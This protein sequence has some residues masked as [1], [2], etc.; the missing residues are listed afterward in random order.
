[1]KCLNLKI[2]TLNC[3]LLPPY[4][5]FTLM[6]QKKEL[7]CKL[8]SN[9]INKI[10]PDI[11]LN[12]EIF[13][14]NFKDNKWANIMQN[15]FNKKY[16]KCKSDIV[17]CK[18]TNNGLY[19][20]IRDSANI[21]IISTKFI[22]CNRGRLSFIGIIRDN[23]FLHTKIYIKNIDKHI[24]I[25]NVHMLSN[26]CNC[27]KK[28]YEKLRRNCIN[29]IMEY[30]EININENDKWVLGGDFNCNVYNFINIIKEKSL[31]YD[32]DTFKKIKST[33]LN[34]STINTNIWFAK[35]TNEEYIDHI[36]TNADMN[37][38]PYSSKYCISKDAEY[39]SDHFPVITDIKL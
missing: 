31:I 26:E 8:I 1:M 3:C 22:N 14:W 24:H 4:S 17:N 25:F 18:L 27:A 21:D 15:S 13:N 23:G 7:R 39:L 33:F 2:V 5:R 16:V 19:T 9:F 32:I 12:Q 29:Q 35:G 6:D 36:H 37:Y 10:N 30:I 38:I 11:I 28:R 20:W 34:Y